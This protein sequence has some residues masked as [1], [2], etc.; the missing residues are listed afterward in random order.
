V[1]SAINAP[2]DDIPGAIRGVP[3]RHVEHLGRRWLV[4]LGPG[5]SVLAWLWRGEWVRVEGNIPEP[6][7]RAADVLIRPETGKT[8]LDST[9]RTR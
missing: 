4:Q 7:V 2:R 6:V 8:A 9:S 3:L 1:A 5:G